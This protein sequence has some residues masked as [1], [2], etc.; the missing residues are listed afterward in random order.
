MSTDRDEEGVPELDLSDA[1]ESPADLTIFDHLGEAYSGTGRAQLTNEQKDGFSKPLS[2]AAEIPREHIDLRALNDEKQTRRALSESTFSRVQSDIETLDWVFVG[3]CT[4]E[5]DSYPKILS[6]MSEN[7]QILAGISVFIGAQPEWHVIG[8]YYDEEL[9]ETAKKIAERLGYDFKNAEIVKVRDRRNLTKNLSDYDDPLSSDVF[10]TASSRS[11]MVSEIMRKKCVAIQGPP[12]TGKTVIGKS[13][14][15]EIAG[16]ESRVLSLQFHQ[17]YSYEDFVRGW[18]PSNSGDLVLKD[19]T[20][21]QFCKRAEEDPGNPYVV[22]IDEINRANVSQV[23]GEVL[24]LIE[25]TKR[26][27]KFAVDLAYSH[28]KGDSGFYVPKNVFLI[29]TMNTADRS[30]AIVDYALRRRF[31]FIDLDPAY[32]EDEFLNFVSDNGVDRTIAEE[33]SARMI[34]LNK[35]ISEDT[36]NLG[37]GFAIGH[38]YFCGKVQEGTDLWR[39]YMNIVEHE[40]A[41]LLREYWSEEDDMAE[42]RISLLSQKLPSPSSTGEQT[43]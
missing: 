7:V 34:E 28:E 1:T 36:R 20:F 15:L 21:L 39:W 38:S 6:Y 23:F 17:S 11:E 31:S 30:L 19:G 22:F 4:G 27:A 24:S 14:S 2:Y 37:P 35:V 13:I 16:E 41:P 42:E 32:G 18:R 25:V 26:D 29:A 43:S 40:I 9:R 12:G 10:L 3:R 33:I 8:M 5:E